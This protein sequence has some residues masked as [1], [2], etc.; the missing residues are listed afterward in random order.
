MWHPNPIGPV[1]LQEKDEIQRFSVQTQKK[2]YVETQQDTTAYKIGRKV[3]P[4]T[5]AA[6]TLILAFQPPERTVRK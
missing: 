1:P 2:F 6:G 3:S 4:E 5:S